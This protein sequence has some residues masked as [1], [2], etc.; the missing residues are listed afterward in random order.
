MAEAISTEDSSNELLI[1][2]HR[3]GGAT[4]GGRRRMTADEKTFP[5]TGLAERNATHLIF[6]CRVSDGEDDEE[7]IKKIFSKANKIIIARREEIEQQSNHRR[8]SKCNSNPR[9]GILL[10]RNLQ[11]LPS[12]WNERLFSYLLPLHCLFTFSSYPRDDRSERKLLED[13]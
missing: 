10:I 11:S 12:E 2:I 1:S 5:P 6:K 4:R 7:K 9:K 3:I 8:A 13:F